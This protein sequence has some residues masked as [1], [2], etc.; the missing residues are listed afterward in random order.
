[1]TPLGI[2]QEVEDHINSCI[3]EIRCTATR[4]RRSDSERRVLESAFGKEATGVIRDYFNV[5]V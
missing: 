1:M 2:K 3:E 4:E 5:Q